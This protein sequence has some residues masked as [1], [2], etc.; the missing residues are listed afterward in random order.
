MAPL[1]VRRLFPPDAAENAA[2]A[3]PAAG[4]APLVI[5]GTEGMLVTLGRCCHPIPGD[6]I[7]GFVSSGRGIV[8]HTR[9]CNNMPEHMNEP[10]KWIGVQWEGESDAEFP[11]AIRVHA[12]NRKGILATVAATISKE[13]ANISNVELAD[14]DG[15]ITTILFMLEVRDRRHLANIMRKLRAIPLVS[16]IA[17]ART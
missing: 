12:E 15:M 3:Q 16:R 17:R 8:V 11:V 6:P 2:G 4:P 5:R 14:R 13:E 1:V 10:E 9:N 7:V